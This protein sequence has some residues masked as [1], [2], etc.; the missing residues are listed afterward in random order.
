M[1]KTRKR[2]IARKGSSHM[3]RR[4][5]QSATPQR[6][7][8]GFLMSV[9]IFGAIGVGWR[10]W[11]LQFTNAD[12]YKMRANHQ[13]IAE[14]EIVPQRGTIFIH[15]GGELYPVATNKSFGLVYV[16]PKDVALKDHDRIIALLKEKLGETVIDEKRVRAKLAKSHDPYEV[17]AHRVDEDIAQSIADAKIAGLHITPEV[18]RFYPAGKTAAQTIGFVGSDGKHYRGRYGIEQTFENVLAGEKG[19]VRQLRDAAGRWIALTDRVKQSAQNGADVILTIDHAVQYETEKILEDA[20]TKHGADSGS[21][22]V[23][24][25]DGTILAM[26]NVPRFDPNVYGS[27]EDISVYRNPIISDAYES[28]SVMKAI[29]MAI[30]IDTGVVT[31][32]ST[33]VDTGVV[34]IGGYDIRN[35]EDKVYGLQTMTQ[36]LDESINTGVIHVERL[37]GHQ[38]FAEYMERFG[39]GSKTGIDLPGESAG[40]LRNLKPPIKPIQFYTASFG[41]GITVTLLQLAQSYAAIANGGMLMAPRIV[42]RIISSDGQETLRPPREMHRVIRE[43][44]ARSVRGMLESVVLN[45]HGK[46]AKIPGYRVGGKTGTAQVAKRN[47]QGYDSGI[48]IGS[49]AGMAPIE[50]PQFIVVTRINN[51]KDVQ[52]AESTAGPVFQKVMHFLL[53]YY[54]VPPTEPIPTKNS[55]TDTFSQSII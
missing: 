1:Q 2:R 48:T 6:W 5:Q 4:T 14:A 37:V 42:D 30:G 52:W 16:S 26:A 11:F 36:V 40:N 22:I 53:D 19:Y 21:I 28:G 54:N 34:K 18:Y 17:I 12:E 43:E 49:F 55:T 29:T 31:P 41:Q 9:F 7:R 32:Q 35:S 47:A 33:Y 45:G 20:V 38:R 44:T 39:F 13:H 50:N 24:R 3:R 27:V 8:V 10:L 51:P 25:P 46:R 15:D 23:M